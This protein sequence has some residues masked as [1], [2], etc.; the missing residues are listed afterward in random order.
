MDEQ[1]PQSLYALAAAHEMV[2][3][4]AKTVEY[5]R[6]AQKL[7]IEMSQPQFAKRIEQDLQVALVAWEQS[8][9]SAP[10]SGATSSK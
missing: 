1:T 6:R 9:G 4:R 3:E 7:G 5:A 10:W 8:R 2:G